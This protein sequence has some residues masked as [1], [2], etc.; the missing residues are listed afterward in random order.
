M[1]EGSRAHTF[2]FAGLLGCLGGLLGDSFAL[3]SIA[4]VGLLVILLTIHALMADH[5]TE[6]TT[7]LRYS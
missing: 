7:Q 4:L 1:E 3:L 6:L 2:A 5:G